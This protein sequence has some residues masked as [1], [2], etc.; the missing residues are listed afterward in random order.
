MRYKIGTVIW[1]A[2]TGE[3]WKDIPAV[4]MN[5]FDFLEEDS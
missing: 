3:G 5:L 2:V 4:Q 1:M